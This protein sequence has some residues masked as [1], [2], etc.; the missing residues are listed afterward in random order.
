MST[1]V[2]L[3]CVNMFI[4]LSIVHIII[5]KL[6]HVFSLRHSGIYGFHIMK[7]NSRKSNYESVVSNPPNILNVI[8]IPLQSTTHTQLEVLNDKST[9]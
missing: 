6:S 5:W 3:K 8:E 4:Y 1:V 2:C 7:M 9:T